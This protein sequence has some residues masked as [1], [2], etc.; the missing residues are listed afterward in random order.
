MKHFIIGTAG[1]VDHGKTMLVKA[2]TGKETDRL[3]EEKE[4]GI[5][6][7]LGFAP[8][9][10]NNGH[11]ASIID[12]PGHEKFIKNMLAG[13][14]GIDLV[15][16]VI[17]ADEGIMPQTREHLDIIQLL[18]IEKG[19]VVVTK[20]DL[21]DQEWLEMVHEEIEEFL[22]DTI[23]AGAPMV[24]VSVVNGTGITQLKELIDQITLEVQPKQFG[25]KTRMHVDR[26]F[27]ITG[28]GTVLTGTLT[29]GEVK[30]G[31]AVEILPE[32]IESRIRTLQVHSQKVETAVAG[33]RVAINLTGVEVG[34]IGRGSVL[35]EPNTLRTSY[36]LDAELI[37]LSSAEKVLTNRTRIR[38]HLGTKEALGRVVLLD[39]EELKP[40][41]TSLVQL[42]LEESVVA[43]KS[44]RFVI[45][46]YSP[47]T[48]IGGGAV[49]DP[50]PS[51]HKRFNQ[52]VLD[53]LKTKQ[54]G[55]PAEL[56]MQHLE[57]S[58]RLIVPLNELAKA[59]EVNAEEFKKSLG[60]LTETGLVKL[61]S[62]EGDYVIPVTF[63]QENIKSLQ[64]ILKNYHTKYPLRTGYPKEEIRSRLFSGLNS[65]LFNLIL[66]TMAE[67]KIIGVTDKYLF[68]FG[69]S[70]KPEPKQEELLKVIENKYSMSDFQPPSW[71]EVTAELKLT[72]QEASELLFYLQ[73]KKILVKLEDNLYLHQQ[74]LADGTD[75][76]KEYL[77][78]KGEVT[79]GEA[80]DLLGTSRKYALPLLEYFD[81]VKVTRRVG[82]KRIAY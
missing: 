12:V 41:E 17:A 5:S 20:S 59:V 6:I 9:Q 52:E 73:E 29:A 25:G 28:F 60:E 56:L 46:S 54:K 77:K 49:I 24:D 26:V 27:S 78:E 2:L 11:E 62:T 15:L 58:H 50:S 3:K 42:E 8:L 22:K 63:Y 68:L 4:R 51:K 55:S 67:D 82:D 34:E 74:V 18:Q 1:H 14:G 47:I 69:F 16:F 39:R 23:L 61:I 33:Q 43:G 45:R 76:I 19:I 75:K 32:G 57:G 53:A 79:L 48:T 36:R 72:D 64:D 30:V 70:P 37:L 13:V 21:V 80:R 31:D 44:D 10:L 66:Q 65:K 40:G 7:E 81:Q 71:S 38:F 35:V